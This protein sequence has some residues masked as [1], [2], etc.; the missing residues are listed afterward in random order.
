VDGKRLV[1][2]PPTPLP[3][4]VGSKS[5]TKLSATHDWVIGNMFSRHHIFTTPRYLPATSRVCDTKYV[6]TVAGAIPLNCFGSV[7]FQISTIRHGSSA[8]AYG[9][10]ACDAQSG[11][12]FFSLVSW[13]RFLGS[14]Q[15]FM[16]VRGLPA[17]QDTA[18]T[19]IT[20][21]PYHRHA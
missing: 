9:S 7:S 5:R 14:F 10:F 4:H 15:M 20:A 2:R 21:P 16:V 19:S 18:H 12:C 6:N 3:G 13:S 8:H 11:N 1:L 17:S